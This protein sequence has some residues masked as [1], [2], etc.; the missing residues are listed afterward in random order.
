MTLTILHYHC[1]CMPRDGYMPLVALQYQQ[2]RINVTLRPIEELLY[3]D[4]PEN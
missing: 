1:V 4:Y 2:M 3:Q